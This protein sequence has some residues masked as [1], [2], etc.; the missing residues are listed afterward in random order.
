MV[1]EG[2]GQDWKAACA[3]C[4]RWFGGRLGWR[5]V[6]GSWTEPSPLGKGRSDL[7]FEN[8]PLNGARKPLRCRP[9]FSRQRCGGDGS[10]PRGCRDRLPVVGWPGMAAG[11]LPRGAG[12]PGIY[13][14]SARSLG[15]CGGSGTGPGPVRLEGTVPPLVKDFNGSQ[16]LSP[17]GQERQVCLSK[18][19]KTRFL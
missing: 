17:G 6:S 10:F 4:C 7:P 14:R 1:S 8:P 9:C 3:G 11:A 16:E 15:S 13:I 12:G 19:K 2:S 5:Q 18:L